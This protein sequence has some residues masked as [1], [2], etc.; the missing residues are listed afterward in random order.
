VIERYLLGEDA[1]R[2]LMS[3]ELQ[4]DIPPI[5]VNRD[6]YF[7][8]LED[9]L[10]T[11]RCLHPKNAKDLD[12]KD[13]ESAAH[14]VLMLSADHKTSVHNVL[15][16]VFT[17]GMLYATKNVSWEE[18][19]SKEWTNEEVNEAVGRDPDLKV[20]SHWLTEVIAAFTYSVIQ[21]TSSVRAAAA[22]AGQ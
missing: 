1:Q 14:Q 19:S 8:G 16:H 18:A 12:A 7:H 2:K 17:T 11:L 21:F 9:I 10:H 22:T 15:V 6:T 4:R 20:E 3:L 13:F 5:P